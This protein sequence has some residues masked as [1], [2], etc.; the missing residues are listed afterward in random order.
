MINEKSIFIL[1]IP[2]WPNKVKI[3]TNTTEFYTMKDN[4]PKAHDGATLKKFGKKL[5][6]IN[7]KG[8]RIIKNSNSVG[9][10]KYWNLNGQAF[11]SANIHWATRSKIVGFYHKYFMKY[12]KEQLKEP[13][14]SFLSYKLNMSIVIYDV[15]TNYTP[16]ITNMWILAKMLEDAIVSAKLLRDDSPEFRRKTSIEYQFITDPTKRKLLVTFEYKKY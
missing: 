3:G 14:P 11:Y 8:S 7:S 5:Y 2:N 10:P 15:F 16:D 6:Y 13:F 9:K 12:I 4:L 1:E